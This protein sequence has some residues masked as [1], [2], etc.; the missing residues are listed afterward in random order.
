MKTKNTTLLIIF[1]LLNLS[2]SAQTPTK[3]RGPQSNGIYPETGLLKTWPASGPEIAWHFDNLGDGFSSPAIANGKIYLSG[4]EEPTGYIYC[5]STDG[6]LL[7]K[8]PYGPEFTESYP[9]A[10][11]TPVIAGDLLYM[12]TGFGVVVC[13]D[14]GNG[15]IKW[16]K[17]TFKDLDGRNIRWGVTETLVVDGDKLYCTP[18]GSKNNVAA[19]N[20][21]DGS[22]VWSSPALGEL[23]AY[24]TPLLIQMQGRKLLINMTE[25]HIIGLDASSGKLLWSYEQTNQ[26]AV[27]ANTPLFYDGSVLCFSGYGQGG[28]KLKLSPD[29]SSVTKEWFNKNL[30]SRIGG[31]VVV[32]GFFYGSGDNSREWRCVDWKTGEEK[33]ASA[34]IGKGAVI[35]ADGML[36]CYSERGELALVPATPAGFN[37][38]SKT[39]VELG[40]AQHWAH[41]VINNGILYI[42]HG[43]SL[44]AY[45]VK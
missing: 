13:M 35:Y 7:W 24:C 23:A 42:R 1:F 8:A 10:R 19:L 15:N 39:K 30:D 36:F 32:N 28:V 44:I 16:K 22:L 20:R 43:K 40:T 41:P 18:G 14:A 2:I 33:Y 27:H 21:F 45:K 5:L 37:V 4:M 12:F 26:W 34:T 6:K 3:W 17:D 25:E 31:A 29:G 9:G 11:T 38:A